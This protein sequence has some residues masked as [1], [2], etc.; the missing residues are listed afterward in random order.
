M[1]AISF[2]AAAAAALLSGRSVLGYFILQGTTIVT[3]RIDPIVTPGKISPH[4]HNLV[5]V[6]CHS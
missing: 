6:S 4:V 3:E 5:G 1:R 2:V